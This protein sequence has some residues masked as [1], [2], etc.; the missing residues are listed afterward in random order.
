MATSP[1]REVSWTVVVLE[2][3]VSH[4]NDALGPWGVCCG[5]CARKNS[6]GA[7]AMARAWEKVNRRRPNLR[8]RTPIPIRS[9]DYSRSRR[10]IRAQD[11]GEVDKRGSRGS[12]VRERT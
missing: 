11:G 7:V 2:P 4:V 5:N 6:P 10:A 12:Q 3:L 9:S 1:W 8:A